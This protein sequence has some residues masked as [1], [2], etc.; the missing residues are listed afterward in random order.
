MSFKEMPHPK[1]YEGFKGYQTLNKH[2]YL[3]MSCY[4]CDQYD[5]GV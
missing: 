1:K 3:A 5:T 2:L 4:T